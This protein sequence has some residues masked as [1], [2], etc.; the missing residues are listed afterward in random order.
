MLCGIFSPWPRISYLSTNGLYQLRHICLFRVL[1][2]CESVWATCCGFNLFG[3]LPWAPSDLAS[4]SNHFYVTVRHFSLRHN[5]LAVNSA[6]KF[7]NL[8]KLSVLIPSVKQQ[9]RG[10]KFQ[11]PLE[12][13]TNAQN[14][15]LLPFSQCPDP[16]PYL[17][18]VASS[19]EWGKSQLAPGYEAFYPRPASA[20]GKMALGVVLPLAADGARW[21]SLTK[22][23][24]AA[25]GRLRPSLMP[26]WW[27]LSLPSWIVY[28]V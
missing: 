4:Q 24:Q 5:A 19:V 20:V 17:L 23:C 10:R 28:F 14:L 8:A 26:S 13:N 22:A 27:L 2:K 16:T 7:T 1:W 6:P 25:P 9:E 3:E 15:L 18:P 11:S 12:T 21:I